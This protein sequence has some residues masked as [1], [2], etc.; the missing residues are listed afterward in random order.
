[1]KRVLE[2][3]FGGFSYDHWRCAIED[4]MDFEGHKLAEASDRDN[5]MEANDYVEVIYALWNQRDRGYG[6]LAKE[7]LSRYS[8]AVKDVTKMPVDLEFYRYDGNSD[9]IFARIEY[10]S[11][12]ALFAASERDGHDALCYAIKD[13]FTSRGTYYSLYDDHPENL[14]SKPL[15]TWNHNELQVLLRSLAGEVDETQISDEMNESGDFL[16]AFWCSMSKRRF[17]R[18]VAARSQ[19]LEPSERKLVRRSLKFPQFPHLH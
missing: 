4:Q 13:A 6:Y 19:K 16:E 12:K 15:R 9:R 14:L 18:E 2:I 1:M 17:E 10:K 7:Y 11:V 8:R 5:P 3:P